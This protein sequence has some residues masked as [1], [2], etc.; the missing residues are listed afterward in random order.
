VQLQRFNDTAAPEIYTKACVLLA[1]ER[2]DLG[3]PLRAWL[4][5]LDTRP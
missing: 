5:A 3:P 1:L 4:D 2:D